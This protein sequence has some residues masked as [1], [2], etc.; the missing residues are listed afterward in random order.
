[1]KAPI[2]A[3]IAG[4]IPMCMSAQEII[5]SS[6]FYEPDFKV[7]RFGATG[8]LLSLSVTNSPVSD[9]MGVPGVS[10]T[11]SA[12]GHAQ[13][14]SNLTVPIVG[15]VLANL[16]AQLAAYTETTGDTLVFGREITTDVELLGIVDPSLALEGLVNDVAGASVL[17]DW[18]AQATVSGLAIAPDQLYEATFSV[19]SGAGLPVGLLESSSFGI[20]TASVTG[21][22]GESLQTL[23][24]LGL[25]SI[26]SGSSTGDYSFLFKSDQA[27]SELDFD[28]SA[29]TGV[30][31]SALGG[32]SGNQNV[33][34]FSGFS[35]SPVPEPSVV[36][37]AGIFAIAAGLRRR[38]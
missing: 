28:F 2:I 36:A 16:D 20:T 14:R 24:L 1:M 8:G 7:R 29:T 10:W 22:S 25:L 15:T 32:T 30:G 13:V 38:R 34:T 31:V 11:H 26:G 27:L 5:N 18:Q 21:A 33:L 19:T 35:V 6:A 17:Y 37:F 12:G 3:C 23:D 4:F 9:T